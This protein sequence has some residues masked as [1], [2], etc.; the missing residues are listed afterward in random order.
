MLV[1][2]F[3]AVTAVQKMQEIR[4]EYLDEILSER[5]VLF[6]KA[7]GPGPVLQVWNE[8]FKIA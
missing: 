2:G 1:Q 4:R 3:S 8:S 6:L 5:N 7:P